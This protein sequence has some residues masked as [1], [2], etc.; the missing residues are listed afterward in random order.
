MEWQGRS[1]RTLEID[2]TLPSRG[3]SHEAWISACIPCDGVDERTGCRIERDHHVPPWRAVGRSTIS[4]PG[5]ISSLL[6]CRGGQDDGAEAERSL[7]E[8]AATHGVAKILRLSVDI[9]LPQVLLRSSHIRADS[10]WSFRNCGERLQKWIPCVGR[11]S[12]VCK[13]TRASRRGGF[14]R[15]SGDGAVRVSGLAPR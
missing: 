4:T 7:H 5:R 9:Q 14:S 12:S 6:H 1:G 8:G 10:E 2:D 15:C 13:R 3:V 11:V